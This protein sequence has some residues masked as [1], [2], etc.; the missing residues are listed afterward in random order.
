MPKVPVLVSVSIA[1]IVMALLL[2]LSGVL[3]DRHGPKRVYLTGIAAYG[4]LVYP[5]FALF[6]SGNLVWFTVALVVVF[7]VVH[8]WFYGAQGTFFASLYPTRVRYTG[9]SVV[10]QFSGIWASGLTPLILT[11]LLGAAHGSP[12]LAC[13]Y[14]V[15]TSAISVVAS[16]LVRRADT[17]LR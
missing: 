4:V 10:Y 16:A 1:A 13:G 11:A 8:A 5:A 12:W 6:G 3:A 7:G 9:L 17:Y 15:A 2:P 14:L